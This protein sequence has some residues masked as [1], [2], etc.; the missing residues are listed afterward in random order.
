MRSSQV[1]RFQGSVIILS[2]NMYNSKTASVKCQTDC[3]IFMLLVM[4]GLGRYLT[5]KYS[6]QLSPRL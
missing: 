5:S 2:K 3:H 1:C 6:W 4:A